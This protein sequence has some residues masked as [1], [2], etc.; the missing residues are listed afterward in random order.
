MVAILTFAVALP[1]PA[2]ALDPDLPGRV[3]D[4]KAR[5]LDVKARI[6]VV[7]ARVLSVKPRVVD[8]AEPKSGA[9]EIAFPSD[10]LFAFGRADLSPAAQQ[11]LAGVAAQIRSLEV[12]RVVIGGHTDSVGDDG[13]NQ[14]LSEQRAE[15][16][17]SYLAR[18]AGSVQFE[19][20]GF[21]E[22]MPLAPNEIDG[23]DNPVGRQRNRRVTITLVT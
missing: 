19:A 2:G 7:K 11:N 6:L 4:V 8:V 13:S 9:T 5:I 12:T 23:K 14:T 18:S 22:T 3:V 15:A 20:R 17:R 10:V 16:V 21:G 1:G